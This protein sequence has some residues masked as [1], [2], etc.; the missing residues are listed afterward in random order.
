MTATGLLELRAGRFRMLTWGE[1]DETVL[2]L[3][4][5]TGVAE[6][7]LPTVRLLSPGRRYV[8]LD[9][10]GHGQSPADPGLDYSAG[11]FVR[12]AVE[13]IEQ[14]GAPLHLVGH[15]MGARVALLAAARY[16]QLLLSTAIIDIGPEASR[17]NIRD[18]VA[19]LDR[20]PE[21]FESREEAL[22]FAFRK[23]TPTGDDEAIFLARLVAADDGSFRW[24]SPAAV[25]AECV[26]RQR[27]RSYWQDWRRIRGRAMLVHG[28]SST[29][30]STAIADR[31][32][33][34]NSSVRFERLDGV[35]HN[36]PLIAPGALAG[37]LE[38][39][40]GV[41]TRIGTQ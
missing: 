24:R 13:A 5:L 20:R 14:I 4:G 29:E 34:E 35:G 3:H 38:D 7:W 18:T 12:D 11:A 15:S 8:A 22:A 2:F 16:P 6:A 10:R 17:A 41:S 9:Q 27:S 23:R 31:M 26:S 36:I 33:H 32:H 28:G 21:R 25:L 1:G 37:L 39:F 30:V 19:G 40:W